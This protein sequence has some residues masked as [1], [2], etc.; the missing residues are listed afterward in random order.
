VQIARDEVERRAA[1]A[2][3]TQVERVRDRLRNLF[4]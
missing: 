3:G 1:D 2:V 4:Q